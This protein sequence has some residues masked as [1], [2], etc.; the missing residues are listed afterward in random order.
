MERERSAEREV[1]EREWTGERAES[2]AHS[3]LTVGGE[4][5]DRFLLTISVVFMIHSDV[6]LVEIY[7]INFIAVS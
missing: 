7:W 6:A 2:A 4:R 3:L 5:D 1:A